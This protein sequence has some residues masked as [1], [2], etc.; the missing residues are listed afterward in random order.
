MV[1]HIAVGL[2]GSAHA[3]AAES[4]ALDLARHL[5]A[6]VHGVHV[7]D[8]TFLEGAFI[9]DIS[10]AMGFE[11]FLNL[12]A[13]MRATLDDVAAAIRSDFTARCEAAGVESQFHLERAG[14]VHGILAAGKL[15]ELLVVGQRGVN[16]RFHEDLLGSTAEML[17]RRSPLPVLVVPQGAE[18]L[19]RP[20]AAYD[21]SPKAVRAL[22]HAAELARALGLD[23]AVVTVDQQEERARARLDEATRYLA[24]YDVRVT[25]EFRHGVEVEKE[26]LAMVQPGGFDLLFLGAHGHSR[27]VELALGSTSQYVAR[28]AAVPIWCVTHV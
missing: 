21:G 24:P 1:K 18:T 3:A 28:R 9:T 14:V 10:G 16:A 15:A 4:L 6:V 5:H 7:I 8:A 27:I 22:Q 13:Q 20:L 11:P 12:Q 2:D 25:Y 23:L 26:L 17:L 19:R